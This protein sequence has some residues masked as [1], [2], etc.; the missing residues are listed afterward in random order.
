M[1]DPH[2]IYVISATIDGPCKLGISAAPDK[3]VRQLQTGH[4]HPL[5]V[6]YRQPL[7]AERV[8]YYEKL[9]HRDNAEKRMTG[10][11]FRMSVSDA[12]AYVQFTVIQYD[13]LT[14]DGLKKALGQK[15]CCYAPLTID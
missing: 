13:S 7:A 6:H 2:F 14:I 10:E 4:A 5:T 12:I 11:W 8:A 3:R 15:Y 1:R 9:L